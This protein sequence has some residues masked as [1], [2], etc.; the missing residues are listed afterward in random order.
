MKNSRS[1]SREQIQT[2]NASTNDVH[3]ASLSALSDESIN[4]S[5]KNSSLEETSFKTAGMT[6]ESEASC[7]D[8]VN[9]LTGSNSALSDI[10]DVR[11]KTP[12][13]QGL[14]MDPFCM[15]ELPEGAVCEGFGDDPFVP[16][17]TDN[18]KESSNNRS[19][20]PTEEFSDA[21]FG[22]DPFV[23]AE[24]DNSKD[25][26]NK[27]VWP[28]TKHGNSDNVDNFESASGHEFDSDPF[29]DGVGSK[30]FT[31]GGFDL[32]PFT[33]PELSSPAASPQELDFTVDPFAI[34]FP[35]NS[36]PFQNNDADD[37]F[38]NVEDI[39]GDSTLAD[40]TIR[41]ASDRD[42]EILTTKDDNITF[43]DAELN[44]GESITSS[45]STKSISSMEYENN[46]PATENRSFENLSIVPPVIP[47]RRDIG[48]PVA[49]ISYSEDE[50]DEPPMPEYLP[51]MPG[52]P[53]PVP[54]RRPPLPQVH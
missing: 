50:E 18:A 53:P 15:A 7:H 14:F 40:D 35:T 52:K 27:S 33:A 9:T 30:Q 10:T 37:P 25:G 34:P 16:S 48:S 19:V 17:Q 54:K 38:S 26:P 45:D 47:P 22:T 21:G 31:S 6:S 23:S 1:T 46:T 36:D 29:A 3:E 11:S 24:T 8:D 41:I 2:M 20:W 12:A 5:G 13:N 39:F 44:L 4:V 42:N 43:N 28:N 32:D 49:S 51:P